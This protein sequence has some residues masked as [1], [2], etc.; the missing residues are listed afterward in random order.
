[1]KPFSFHSRIGWKGNVGRGWKHVYF[2][3]SSYN[4]WWVLKWNR[5][6]ESILQ[7][8][9]REIQC[10]FPV[11]E[12]P[13]AQCL[14]NTLVRSVIGISC[15]DRVPNIEIMRR[16]LQAETPW[17]VWWVC[18]WLKISM[19]RR[20]WNGFQWG[21]E[22]DSDGSSVCRK[23]QED[24]QSDTCQPWHAGETRKVSALYIGCFPV[25]GK[26]GCGDEW[27]NVFLFLEPRTLHFQNWF[28]T[29]ESTLLK[30]VLRGW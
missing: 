28:Q 12:T 18:A 29:D 3:K 2:Y 16:G 14:W 23:T 4:F 19:F 8:Q 13:E 22:I 21:K 30:L 26:V 9:R 27:R 6:S 17:R 5:L 1:M 24:W 15:K 11:S 7:V 20:R 25:Q 10:P